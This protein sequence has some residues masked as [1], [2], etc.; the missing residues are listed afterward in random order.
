MTCFHRLLQQTCK[1]SKPK[2]HHKRRHISGCVVSEGVWYGPTGL[3]CLDM[4]FPFNA[5]LTNGV[6]HVSKWGMM[7]D[8][9]KHWLT[10]CFTIFSQKL[11]E[12]CVIYATKN[13][14]RGIKV[15]QAAYPAPQRPFEHLLRVKT[16]E[17]G[18]TN[19][20]QSTTRWQDRTL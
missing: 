17:R 3:P 6:D 9:S 8:I 12:S 1:T 11:C 18:P 2:Q 4:L 10:R 13:S 16:G 5:K 14:G 7:S 20:E 15:Q 19:T